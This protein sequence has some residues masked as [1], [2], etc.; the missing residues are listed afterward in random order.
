M[1]TAQEKSITSTIQKIK[2]ILEEVASNPDDYDL[3]KTAVELY[4][5]SQNGA[6]DMYEALI[7]A[8]D[9]CHGLALEAVR[10][11]LAKAK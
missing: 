6:Q 9:W 8:Q 10:K 1:L 4:T 2:N 5:M 3:L 11:A 7:K